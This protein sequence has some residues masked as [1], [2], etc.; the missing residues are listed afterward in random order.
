MK[1]D[2]GKLAHDISGAVRHAQ[3]IQNR[4]LSE[5][6]PTFTWRQI[7]ELPQAEKDALQAKYTEWLKGANR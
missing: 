3:A 2:Y 1:N 5:H 4:F 6:L 7:R